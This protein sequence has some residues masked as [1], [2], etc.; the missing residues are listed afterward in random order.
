MAKTDTFFI[1]ADLN[2]LN[3]NTYQE[4]PIDLGTYVNALEK[5]VLRIK[6][7][8]V[9]YSDATGRSIDV[10]AG[11]VGVAQYQ[12]LTQ[13]Q[14]DIVLASDNAV[15][16]SGRA[17]HFNEAAA[18]GLATIVTDSNDLNPVT[19]GTE[20]YI[21]AVDTIFL[22]GAGSLGFVEEPFVSV[23]LECQ[24]ETLTTAKAMALALSQQGN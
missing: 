24:V 14:G 7:V 16:A 1:R 19:F 23:I 10:A 8:Q 20:G 12:L 18:D 4:T 13:S 9:S 2:V 11:D 5:S 21:V 6:S 15:V 17:H 3:T 22:G